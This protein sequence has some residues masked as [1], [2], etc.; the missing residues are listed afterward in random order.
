M[1]CD[2]PPGRAAA[3]WMAASAGLPARALCK[4][5]PNTACSS[6]GALAMLWPLLQGALEL[7]LDEVNENW[8]KTQAK[9]GEAELEVSKRDT[10]L[11][12]SGRGGRSW[13]SVQAFL[14]EPACSFALLLFA[15]VHECSRF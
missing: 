6:L 2:M 9:L 1:G 7:R 14:L 5:A 4:P 3:S 10:L 11:E 12:V 15:R 8:R 13:P